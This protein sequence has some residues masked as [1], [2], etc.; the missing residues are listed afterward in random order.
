M[1]RSEGVA[2]A[3]RVKRRL[4]PVAEQFRR[5]EH[6]RAPR[7]HLFHHAAPH[8]GAVDRTGV[9]LVRTVRVAIDE[10][11]TDIREQCPNVEHVVVRGRA[12]WCAKRFIFHI[13]GRAN[14]GSYQKPLRRALHMC[15]VERLHGHASG[16]AGRRGRRAEQRDVE[17]AVVELRHGEAA[18]RLWQADDLEIVAAIFGV[19]PAA[20]ADGATIG[21]QDRGRLD[22]GQ[23][24]QLLAAIDESS[25]EPVA[26][27]AQ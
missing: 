21:T 3:D 20:L 18:A 26:L 6:R 27:V 2:D 9:V 1:I 23:S 19:E 17:V 12:I 25:G 13:Q 16:Q 10:I 7:L 15:H 24:R 14:L 5:G 11:E 22:I 4:F 8:E